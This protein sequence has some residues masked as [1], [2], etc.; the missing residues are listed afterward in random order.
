[1]RVA[2]SS[3]LL[4]SASNSR[5]RRAPIEGI[6]NPRRHSSPSRHTHLFPRGDPAHTSIGVIGVSP[7]KSLAPTA[8]TS[9][10]SFSSFGLRSSSKIRPKP[11]RCTPMFSSL[12]LHSSL[13]PVVFPPLLLLCASQGGAPHVPFPCFSRHPSDC[14]CLLPRSG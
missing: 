10:A 4:R 8:H 6:G 13:L 5:H 11:S 14:Q 7:A 9:P 12:S 1:M 2:V 3:A